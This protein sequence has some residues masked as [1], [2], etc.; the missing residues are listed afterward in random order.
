[1]DNS[2]P[3]QAIWNGQVGYRFNINDGSTL[4]VSLNVNNLFDKQPWADPGNAFTFDGVNGDL[5]G[6][7]YNLNVNYSY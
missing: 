5:L 7:R 6:R 4:N 1:A 2:Y 3:T